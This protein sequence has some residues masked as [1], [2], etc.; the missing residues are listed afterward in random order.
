MPYAQP[1]PGQSYSHAR[2]SSGTVSTSNPKKRSHHSQSMNYFSNIAN[3]VCLFWFN[4]FPLLD[5]AFNDAKAVNLQLY[6]LQRPQSSM[7]SPSIPGAPS[8]PPPQSLKSPTGPSLNPSDTLITTDATATGPTAPLDN[9]YS[10]S[11]TPLSSPAI[12]NS[13]PSF[14]HQRVSSNGSVGGSPSSSVPTSSLTFSRWSVPS[15]SFRQFIM[16]VIRHTQLPLTA[17]SLALFYILRLKKL[18]PRPIVGNPNSEYQVFSVALMLANKFLDDNTYTNKT[19][20]DVTHLPLREISTMEVEFLANMRYSLVVTAS[21]WENWQNQLRTWL[22]VHIFWCK[23]ST[24]IGSGS[25]APGV[26]SSLMG[27]PPAMSSHFHSVPPPISSPLA[28]NFPSTNPNNGS[29]NITGPVSSTNQH[30]FTNSYLPLNGVNNPVSTSTA[31]VSAAA[32]AAANARHLAQAQAQTK[33]QIKA[34]AQIYQ[35]NQEPLGPGIESR[36]SSTIGIP[37]SKNPSSNKRSAPDDSDRYWYDAQQQQPPSKKISLETP[38]P[39]VSQPS[40]RSFTN[41]VVSNQSQQQQ[42]ALP[43]LIFPLGNTGVG[44]PNSVTMKMKPPTTMS[45][46]NNFAN[47]SASSNNNNGIIGGNGLNNALL[48]ITKNTPLTTVETTQAM[49]NPR[50]IQFTQ[51]NQILPPP[52]ANATNMLNAINSNTQS[53]SL[54]NPIIQQSQSQLTRSPIRNL[55]NLSIIPNNTSHHISPPTTFM[56]VSNGSSSMLA[57]T[58]S[59]LNHLSNGPSPTFSTGHVLPLPMP[60]AIGTKTPIMG[61]LGPQSISSATSSAATTPTY[62]IISATRLSSSP[63][64]PVFP[65]RT[66][67]IPTS[68]IRSPFNNVNSMNNGVGSLASYGYPNASQNTNTVS[69]ISQPQHS[70]LSGMYQQGHNRTLSQNSGIG[71]FATNPGAPVPVGAAG[72][73][74]SSNASGGGGSMSL[75]ANSSPWRLP[76]VVTSQ[77][78]TPQTQQQQ[79]VPMYYYSITDYKSRLN[80]QPHC[81]VYTQGIPN[82]PPLINP[83]LSSISTLDN[84]L[85]GYKSTMSPQHMNGIPTGNG[86]SGG[87]MQLRPPQHQQGGTVA[88]NTYLPGLYG[89]QQYTQNPLFSVS[90]IGTHGGGNAPSSITTPN[91]SVSTAT[92][93]GSQLVGLNIGNLSQQQQQQAPPHTQHQLLPNNVNNSSGNRS[94]NS[95]GQMLPD[96]TYPPR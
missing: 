19:W 71:S 41:S 50:M 26:E 80:P 64:A 62:G 59:T 23:P 52:S 5:K 10:N 42:P 81:G 16:S 53:R 44:A 56:P 24:C 83:P 39:S 48:P 65:I 45:M 30:T 58:A 88:A 78:S 34:Q 11:N 22:A 77:T 2:S 74:G 76:P 75:S 90:S 32:V 29:S 27:S 36:P 15:A 86:G 3:L 69:Q 31:N 85:L 21:D 63:Y 72:A 6:T 14:S 57:S 46:L 9:I 61:Q 73:G 67:L 43:P 82:L 47:G 25:L 91:N 68:N 55:P 54:T 92:T 87:G 37:I 79:Q 1:L 40:Y 13:Q 35:L 96:F 70:G 8:P 38:P 4:E 28:T 93:P 60:G 84:E 12:V 94:S 66:L 49:N 18:S 20:A 7:P 17:V 89:G 95:P 51:P 33:S